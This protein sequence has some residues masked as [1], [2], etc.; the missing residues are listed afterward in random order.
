MG[1]PCMR[2]REKREDFPAFRRSKLDGSRIKVGPHNESYE[3]IPKL[4]CFVKLQEVGVLSYFDYSLSKDHS[5]VMR[6]SPNRGAGFTIAY[7]K[8]LVG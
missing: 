5:M 1:E 3:W 8:L 6:Y 7:I 2:W 4:M